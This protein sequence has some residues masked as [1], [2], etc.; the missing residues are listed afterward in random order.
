MMSQLVLAIEAIGTNTVAADDMAVVD[1]L[2]GK[3]LF[4]VTS[5]V[6]GT[7]EGVGADVAGVEG[8]CCVVGSDWCY[9]VGGG[10]SCNLVS[11]EGGKG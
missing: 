10:G 1:V 11:A 6:S 7:L 8:W 3:V 2:G 9:G 4:V 5:K